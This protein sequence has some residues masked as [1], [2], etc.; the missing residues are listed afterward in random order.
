MLIDWFT[1][2][3]QAVNFALLVWLMKRFLYKPILNAIAKRDA[4]VA[5]VLADADTKRDE[6]GREREEFDRKNAEFDR[7]RDARSAKVREAASAEGERLLAEARAKADALSV[8]RQAARRSEARSLHQALARQAQQEVFAIA[9]KALADLA[10]TSLEE[11]ICEVFIGRLRELEGEAKD[12]LA[13]ALASDEA[14]ALVRSVAELSSD[15]RA[16]IQKA[17]DVTFSMEV[18]LRFETSP[19]LV[20]GIELSANGC[21]L[22]W[23]IAEYLRSLAKSVGDLVDEGLESEG[24]ALPTD[25]SALDGVAVDGAAPALPTPAAQKAI[26]DG[27]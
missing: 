19:D 27:S 6:A 7:E 23:S 20:S 11:R 21:K 4:R 14:P 8:R 22:G 17:L 10:T 16:S 12:E 9:R 18:P 26:A 13:K 24:S 2:V 15:Q 3:A 1:V 5:A 25:E